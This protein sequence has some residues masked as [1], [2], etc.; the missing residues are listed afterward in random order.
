MAKCFGRIDRS[1][2]GPAN[3]INC[4]VYNNT[5]RF[6]SFGGCTYF[7]FCRKSRDTGHNTKEWFFDGFEH[8]ACVPTR[9]AYCVKFSCS[10]ELVS[11]TRLAGRTVQSRFCDDA[12]GRAAF[13]RESAPARTRRR[14]YARSRDDTCKK[15]RDFRAR[16][17]C[18]LSTTT[19]TDRCLLSRPNTA[20]TGL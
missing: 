15:P 1:V 17:I 9:S 5:P 14:R 10:R 8:T 13:R 20:N 3:Y 16:S 18:R 7:H 6:G 12:R 11:K 19:T 4:T 2:A